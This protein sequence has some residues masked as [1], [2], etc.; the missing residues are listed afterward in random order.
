MPSSSPTAAPP[1][2][3]SRFLHNLMEFAGLAC[4]VA[5]AYFVWPPAALLAAGLELIVV[6][7][8]R[9]LAAD[10]TRVSMVERIA[11]AVAAYRA[12]GG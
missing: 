11:R 5:F 7:N 1:R 8:M 10:P 12:A 9:D 3:R 6:A 4:L 2:R